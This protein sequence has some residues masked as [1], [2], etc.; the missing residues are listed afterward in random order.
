MIL[1]IYFVVLHGELSDNSPNI[2]QEIV[3]VLIELLVMMSLLIQYQ[4][5]CK[6]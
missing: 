2:R 4:G 1:A 5:R 6:L 3:I